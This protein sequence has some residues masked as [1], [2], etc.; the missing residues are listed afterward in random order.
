MSSNKGTAEVW[1][2]SLIAS[3][4]SLKLL[5]ARVWHIV[6]ANCPP[7]CY[8]GSVGLKLGRP[9]FLGNK[10]VSDSLGCKLVRNCNDSDSLG[11]KLVRNCINTDSFACTFPRIALVPIVQVANALGLAAITIALVAKIYWE[12]Q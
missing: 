2:W 4:S 1:D 5:A 6:G 8:G 12:L 11:C 7:V 3:D 9:R 10:I